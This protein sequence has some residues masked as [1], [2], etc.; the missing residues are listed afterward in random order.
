MN[1]PAILKLDHPFAAPP[2]IGEATLV[3]PGIRW[4]RM[5]L[6]FALDHINLWLAD[7]DDGVAAIDCGYGDSVTRDAW[8]RHFTTTMG[9]RPVKTLVATHFHPDHLGN[10]EW[11][12]TRFGVQVTMTH[13]EFLHAHA[14]WRDEASLSVASFVQF[15]RTHGMTEEHVQALAARGPAYRRGVPTLPASFAR[16]IDGDLIELGD[17]SFRVI[18]GFG[19]SPEHAA[20]YCAERAVLISGDM[21]LPRISTNISA[22]P[23]EPDGD[24]LQRFLDSLSRFDDLPADTLVLPSHGLPFRGIALRVAQLR[25][26]HHAR[27]AELEDFIRASAAPVSAADVLPTLFRRE[28]DLQQRFFAMGEAIA[29]LNHLWQQHRIERV[30][31]A[32]HSLRF[33]ALS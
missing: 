4:L 13:A 26:H 9:N 30:G 31:G 11:L 20:L 22:W 17:L 15:L 21:L 32:Q 10:A 19:H 2:P 23:G 28:L 1:A 29:H 12:A 3:A 6:P 24:P 7:G 25:A 14:V 8:Q 5:P 16:I 33:R 27:L 18:A